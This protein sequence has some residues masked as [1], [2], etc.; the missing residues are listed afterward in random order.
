MMKKTAVFMGLTSLLFGITYA[1]TTTYGKGSID[2]SGT[3]N[4]LNCSIQVGGGSVINGL[5]NFGTS[6]TSSSKVTAGTSLSSTK[7]FDINLLGC[8]TTVASGVQTKF[9][10][11]EYGSHSTWIANTQSGGNDTIGFQII[12]AG[13]NAVG[14]GT[15]ADPLSIINPNKGQTVA[16]SLRYGAQLIAVVD[17]GAG[18]LGTG[19]AKAQ[20]NFTVTSS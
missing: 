20:V 2:L 17:A 10:F 1:T 18:G 16:E 12:G 9:T 3:I 8:S 13:S 7:M 4:N 6:Y 15:P 5:I 19:T 14:S 11:A